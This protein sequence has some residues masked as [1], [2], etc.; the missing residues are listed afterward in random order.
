MGYASTIIGIFAAT[1]ALIPFLNY[2][3]V[4]PSLMGLFLGLIAIIKSKKESKS[5]GAGIA[6]TSLNTLALVLVL[7]WTINLGNKISRYTN[8]FSFDGIN[9]LFGSKPKHNFDFSEKFF[10]KH[11][12]DFNDLDE[13]DDFGNNRFN[14][15][16]P[17]LNK[18]DEP[19]FI[20]KFFNGNKIPGNKIPENKIPEKDLNSQNGIQNFL[21]EFNN[22]NFP[23]SKNFNF[24]FQGDLDN[25]KNNPQNF[26]FHFKR[27]YYSNEKDENGKPKHYVEEYNGNSLEEFQKKM[28][29]GNKDFKNFDPNSDL[30]P[31]LKKFNPDENPIQNDTKKFEKKYD[32]II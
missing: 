15:L 2:F 27:E 8:M 20:Q 11:K 5:R 23:N 19:N 10:P 9:N 12:D 28:Q 31:N 30:K 22:Q 24:K 3:I 26:K 7:V 1:F 4:I 18:K 25:N 13:N 16:K 29:R 32:Q 21:K 17:K 6:G 14:N